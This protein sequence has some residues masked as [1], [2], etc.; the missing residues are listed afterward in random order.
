M[1]PG[2]DAQLRAVALV[3][4]VVSRSLV[5]LTRV[6]AQLTPAAQAL[7]DTIRATSV[8]LHSVWNLSGCWRG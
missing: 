2:T 7:Y 3:E 4:P 5:L 6:N 1:H 8:V